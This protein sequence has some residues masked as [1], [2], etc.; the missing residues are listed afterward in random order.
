MSTNT[1]KANEDIKKN[2]TLPFFIPEI[3]VI[4]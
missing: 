4:L 2:G 1:V 3:N